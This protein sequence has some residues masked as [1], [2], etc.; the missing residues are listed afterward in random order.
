MYFAAIDNLTKAV[1]NFG[2]SL[3]KHLPSLLHLI[4]QRLDLSKDAKYKALIDAIIKNC[5]P[6]GRQ[7]VG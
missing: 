4:K 1:D 5:G 3:N 2:P 7:I 6:T